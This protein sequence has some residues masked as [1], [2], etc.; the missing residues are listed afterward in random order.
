MGQGDD[1]MPTYINKCHERIIP[2]FEM[3][4]TDINLMARVM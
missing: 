3:F 1:A 4:E 2:I